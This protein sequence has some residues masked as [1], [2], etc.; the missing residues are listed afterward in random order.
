MIVC[1][2]TSSFYPLLHDFLGAGANH[3][4]ST[5]CSYHAS[6]TQAHGKK[7]E[8]DGSVMPENVDEKLPNKAS[9]RPTTSV[10]NDGVHGKDALQQDSRE[11]VGEDS[12]D[13]GA[14]PEISLLEEAAAGVEPDI[15]S[16][17]TE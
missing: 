9:P 4:L 13:Y 11:D 14:G 15:Q 8:E 1:R 16:R 6:W 5:A 12:A 3:V 17:A 10:K 7:Q 2:G